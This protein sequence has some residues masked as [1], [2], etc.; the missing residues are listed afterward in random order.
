METWYERKKQLIA[1]YEQTT[2][3]FHTLHNVRFKLLALLPIYTGIGIITT[4]FIK[5]EYTFIL[6]VLFLVVTMGLTI[7][8]QRN[9]QIYDRLIIRAKYLE[10]QLQFLPL[11][12]YKIGGAFFDRP[13]RRFGL[14]WHDLG[15]SIVYGICFIF[16]LYLVVKGYNNQ[17]GKTLNVNNCEFCIASS[18]F[19]IYTS[20]LI[21]LA[22]INDLE[23]KQK[24]KDNELC[25]WCW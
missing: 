2:A 8:D 20:I 23:T 24:E 4:G 5:S 10:K 13:P 9:T 21:V 17:Y 19:I 14:I 6:S 1:D 18:G 25:D 22:V 15:L 3:Y 12:S 7:Y 16:W 11:K